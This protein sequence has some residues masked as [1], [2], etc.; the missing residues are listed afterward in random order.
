MKDIGLQID[1]VPADSCVY[2]NTVYS[3]VLIMTDVKTR[4]LFAKPIPEVGIRQLLIRIL[5]DIF[6]QFGVPGNFLRCPTAPSIVLRSPVLK[7]VTSICILFLI[8][9]GAKHNF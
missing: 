6:L 4:Y 7:P 3:H 9:I 1:L 5:T 2:V 8:W